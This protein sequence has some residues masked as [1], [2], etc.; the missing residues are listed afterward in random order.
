MQHGS[1]CDVCIYLHAI[2]DEFSSSYEISVFLSF[3]LPLSYI[4][5]LTQLRLRSRMRRYTGLTRTHGHVGKYA[6]DYISNIVR[7]R[8]SQ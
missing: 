8:K 5:L 4:P 7:R 1:F 6:E 2:C 3:S